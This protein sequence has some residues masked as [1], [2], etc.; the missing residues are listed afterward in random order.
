MI[1]LLLLPLVVIATI[2][3]TTPSDRDCALKR[4]AYEF[5]VSRGASVS[6][7][8]LWDS[9]GLGRSCASG[10]PRPSVMPVPVP[11]PTVPPS[12]LR[13]FVSTTGSDTHAGTSSST[14]FATLQRAKLAVRGCA[15]R[16]AAPPCAATVTIAPGVY[17]LNETLRLDE[18]DSRVTWLAQEPGSVKITGSLRIPVANLTWLPWKS[19]GV[20]KAD[21]SAVLPPAV[22]AALRAAYRLRTPQQA[23]DYGQPPA[24]VNQLFVDDARQILARWPNGLPEEESGLCLQAAAPHWGV[25]EGGCK[26]WV[27][28]DGGVIDK[29]PPGIPRTKK[30]NNYPQ[31]EMKFC[32]NRGLSPKFGCPECH[33]CGTFGPY[34]VTD[35][36]LG[37]PV[38]DGRTDVQYSWRNTSLAAFWSD[39]FSRPAGV[40]SA[41]VVNRSLSRS[42]SNP[43]SG[44]VQ[45]FHGALWG[46]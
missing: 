37:H 24:L 31:C 4:L 20:F 27:T 43:R 42:W 18:R 7:L 35:P 19:E 44:S 34:F 6:R 11:L 13:F 10:P 33:T 12:P 46:S 5:G 17:D 16:R 38:Y 1:S 2:T 30:L 29:Q 15:C 26:S 39:I 8:A 40:V 41:A 21:L 23:W 32:V 22:K 28:P 36:P 3:T 45:M 14:A 9:L 25:V